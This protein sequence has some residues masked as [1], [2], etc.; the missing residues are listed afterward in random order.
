MLLRL[1]VYEKTLVQH[2]NNVEHQMAEVMLLAYHKF[3]VSIELFSNLLAIF[4]LN[5]TS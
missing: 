3:N 4:L 5:Y 2:R 1:S